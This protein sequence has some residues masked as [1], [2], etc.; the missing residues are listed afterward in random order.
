MHFVTLAVSGRPGRQPRTQSIKGLACLTRDGPESCR[1]PTPLGTAQLPANAASASATRAA[2][3]RC[4]RAAGEADLGDKLCR[5]WS[6]M[7]SRSL[8]CG[9]GGAAEL[10]DVEAQCGREVET[11]LKLRVVANARA[12]EI[13]GR[14]PVRA[15]PTKQHAELTLG[16]CNVEDS[17]GAVPV[18]SR[19]CYPRRRG[20]VPQRRPP[21]RYTKPGRSR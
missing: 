1:R 7:R 16:A 6:R 18:G 12:S 10:S 19:E 8:R 15:H 21:T 20:G 9:D 5:I 2:S 3:A 11:A 17:S 4:L 14:A 13:V